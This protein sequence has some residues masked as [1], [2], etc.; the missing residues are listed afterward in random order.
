VKRY[1]DGL[2][3]IPI[4]PQVTSKGLS[5][6]A[7]ISLGLAKIVEDQQLEAVSIGD[8]DDELHAVLKCRPCLYVP[9][10]FEHGVVVGSEGDLGG[11][12]AQ[13][14]LARLSG[15]PTLFTEIFTYDEQQNQILVGHAGMHDIR[16]AADRSAVT[17]TPDYEYPKEEAGVWMAF[18]VK[19]GPVTLLSITSDQRGF[20]F[21]ATKG[22]AL[23]AKG[24]LQGYPSA[25]IRLEM[26]LRS[27]FATTT[28]IG[29]TQHWALVPGDLTSGI[30]RLAHVLGIN[31]TILDRT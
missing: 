2:K 23:L 17:I 31:C 21:V 27:F 26:P 6:A 11:I 8:C 7:R 28:T 10:V 20:H 19:P 25:L 24:R 13:L 15:S 16:L 12:L 4:S 30:S 3:G 9:S 29:T 22:E 14:I 18:S 1:V 5:E